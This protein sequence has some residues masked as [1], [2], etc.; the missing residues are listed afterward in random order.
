MLLTAVIPDPRLIRKQ[1]TL[2]I[3]HDG[4]QEHRVVCQQILGPT[5]HSNDARQNPF[6]T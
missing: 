3:G 5:A 4:F 1:D 6:D 2:D